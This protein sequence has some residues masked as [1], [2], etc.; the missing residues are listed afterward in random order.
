V[1]NIG[2]NTGAKLVF[3]ASDATLKLLARIHARHP[4]EAEFHPFD[5]WDDFLILARDVKADDNLLIVMSRKNRISYNTAMSRIPKYLNKYFS[6]NNFILIY[7]VQEGIPVHGIDLKNPS[8]LS[9][10]HLQELMDEIE[11]T[12]NKLF[13][14]K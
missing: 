6:S 14:K 2:R 1:W 8:M 10:F 11:Y 12:I 4:V 7:P 9:S 13:R 3:F 5:N